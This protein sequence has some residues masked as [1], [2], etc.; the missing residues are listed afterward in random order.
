[1]RTITKFGIL[2]SLIMFFLTSACAQSQSTA[3]M[4]IDPDPQEESTEETVVKMLDLENIAPPDTAT[5]P[6]PPTTTFTKEPS[7]TTSDDTPPDDSSATVIPSPTKSC[8]DKAELV[9]HLTLRNNTILLTNH[10]YGKI[11]LVKNV[12]TCT[13]TTEYSLVFMDGEIMQSPERIQL[14]ANI[15]PGE[16]IELRIPVIAPDEEGE[17]Q[18]SWILQNEFGNPFGIGE[19]S[20]Q[21]LAIQVVVHQAP[22][23]KEDEECP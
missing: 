14:E 8:T 19:G 9:N 10:S 5:E 22:P 16:T 6:P 13:W 11:W 4:N 21:P 12:G 15:D 3:Q 20:D 1:M 17:Y 7:P 18:A 23:P 2:I